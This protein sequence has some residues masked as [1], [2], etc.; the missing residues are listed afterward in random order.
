[1]MTKL[2]LVI[3]LSP[4]FTGQGVDIDHRQRNICLHRGRP[5]RGGDIANF[6]VAGSVAIKKRFFRWLIAFNVEFGEQHF[7]AAFMLL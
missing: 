1:M 4:N 6:V 3:D 7:W 5:H 2:F